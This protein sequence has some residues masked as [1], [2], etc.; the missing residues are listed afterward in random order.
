MLR[1]EKNM[2]SLL[3]RNWQNLLACIV[4]NWDRQWINWHWHHVWEEGTVEFLFTVSRCRYR[5]WWDS[6]VG[7]DV[8]LLRA[9]IGSYCHPWWDPTAARNGI[10]LPTHDGILLWPVMGSYWARDGIYCH[11][12]WDPTAVRDVILVRPVM[13]SYCGLCWDPN[14]GRHGIP[15]WEVT[16]SWWV[17]CG[18]CM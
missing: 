3:A 18:S 1:T 8:M 7:R 12:W 10:L 11:S 6:T 15:Q 5:R 13:G 14:M 4:L 16:G 9:M 2:S 17:D